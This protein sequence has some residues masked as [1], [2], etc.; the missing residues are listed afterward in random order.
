MN[1]EE[2]NN[3]C[4]QIVLF[5]KASIEWKYKYRFN[6]LLNKLYK[7]IDYEYKFSSSKCE[8]GSIYKVI[9]ELKSIADNHTQIDKSK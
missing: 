3:I 6:V 4:E 7:L 1:Q 5:E 8:I 9:Q 2:Y